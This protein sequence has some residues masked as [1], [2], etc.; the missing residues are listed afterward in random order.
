MTGL[1]GVVVLGSLLLPRPVMFY[2]GRKFA[3][4]GTAEGLAYWN[5]LWRYP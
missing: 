2:F 3:T 1:F 5:G 4:D